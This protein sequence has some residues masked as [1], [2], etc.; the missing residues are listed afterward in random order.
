MTRRIKACLC[1]AALALTA[2]PASAHRVGIP[3]TTL[4]WNARTSVWEITHRLPAHDMEL[5]FGGPVDLAQI[6]D[7]D[8]SAIVNEYV[9]THFTLLGLMHLTYVGAEADNDYIW[10]YYELRGP[11]QR[12]ILRNRLLSGVEGTA[13]GLV[14]VEAGDTV[15]SLVYGDGDIWKG[16]SL[17][18]APEDAS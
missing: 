8:L 7:A 11:D 4:E 17:N 1:A 2:G 14:N 18:R 15:Q 12:V 5:A 3:V 6:S 10:A 13:G 9:L 16:V